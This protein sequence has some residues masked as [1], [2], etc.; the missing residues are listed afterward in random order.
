MQVSQRHVDRRG[1][2]L[3]AQRIAV[4][5]H[6]KLLHA[7][8]RQGR[9]RIGEQSRIDH[10]HDVRQIALA[11]FDTRRVVLRDESRC[12]LRDGDFRCLLVLL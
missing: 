5:H 6:I 11:A 4:H 3:S 9:Q 7:R 10:R 1:L 8:C 2:V 12:K